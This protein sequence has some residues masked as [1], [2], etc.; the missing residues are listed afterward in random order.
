MEVYFVRN[1]KK[2]Y[3]DFIK[4]IEYK[5]LKPF[6]KSSSFGKKV[7]RK[8]FKVSYSSFKRTA[9]TIKDIVL[10]NDF[11]LFATFTF[12][13]KK[14]D[15]FNY[16][17][18]KKSM[19]KWFNHQ[20]DRNSP[21][22]SYLVIPE[23]HKSGAW[24]FH[25]LM[26][27]YNGGLID[28]GVIK[29]GRVIYNFKTY[30]LGFTTCVKIDNKKAVASYI[31]KYITK[32]LAEGFNKRK[33]FCSRGLKRPVKTLNSTDLRFLRKNFPLFCQPLYETSETFVYIIPK[34]DTS[35]TMNILPPF[36]G[37]LGGGSRK[38]VS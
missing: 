1:I 22:L 32:S 30:T 23:Q 2:D 11:E 17:S 26:S 34:S 9:D 25:A 19:L 33:F 15:S 3:G 13:P 4:Y 16:D 7:A 18:C 6:F 27:N 24:H 10:C 35:A 20:K 12:D 38:K 37:G 29:N 5:E 31:T 14:K 8:D 28:S 36:E 21:F